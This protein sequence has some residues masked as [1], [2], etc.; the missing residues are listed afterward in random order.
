[1]NI[2]RTEATIRK[3]RP[4]PEIAVDS[5]TK[6][7]RFWVICAV[8]YGRIRLTI[9]R[10]WS[11]FSLKNAARKS[12]NV[13]S[14]GTAVKR[15]VKASEPARSA[16]RSA[17]K[18]RNVSTTTS[19]SV[20]TTRRTGSGMKGAR[21]FARSRTTVTWPFASPAFASPPPSFIAS[22]P[23]PGHSVRAGEKQA[24]AQNRR[25][26]QLHRLALLRENDLPPGLRPQGAGEGF[27]GAGLAV[28][29]E[30]RARRLPDPADPLY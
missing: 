3:T 11:F 14:N 5:A 26:L 21:R 7:R 17:L 2:S 18:P 9:S 22:P 27:G 12:E 13:A 15:V 10:T 25:S 29:E 4:M 28:D 20:T 30:G 19:R 23:V 24:P 8:W 16:P 6:S 1:M